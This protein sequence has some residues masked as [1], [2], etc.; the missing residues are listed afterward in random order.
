MREYATRTDQMGV[1]SLASDYRPA[2]I[3]EAAIPIRI[4]KWL[5]GGKINYRVVGIVWGGS[6]PVNLLEIRLNPDEDYV[7][8]ER[9]SQGANGPWSFWTHTWMPKKPA[10]YS[11]RLR[12]K[13]PSG[14]TRRMDSGYFVRRVEITEVWRSL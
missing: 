6:R 1:P 5:V 10:S 3:E 9:F 12:V 13:D 7:P 4:E 8:V 11:I 14:P 2:S